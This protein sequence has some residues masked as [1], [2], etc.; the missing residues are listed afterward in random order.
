MRALRQD[1]RSF[2][3]ASTPMLAAWPV[4]IVEYFHA[5]LNQYFMTANTEQIDLL[6]SLGR[7]KT[8]W[9]RTGETMKGV[10]AWGDI[11][12]I[13]AGGTPTE[14]RNVIRFYGSPLGPNTHFYTAEVYG[15]CGHY[16]ADGKTWLTDTCEEEILRRVEIANAGNAHTLHYEGVDFRTYVTVRGSPGNWINPPV[17]CRLTDYYFPN[18]KPMRTVYRLYNGQDGTRTRADGSRIDGNHRYTTSMTIA[19]RMVAQGWTFE[20]PVWCERGFELR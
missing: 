4:T 18:E 20:G 10:S 7:D 12:K 5:G 8:G 11:W 6:D 13:S 14:P 9:A 16:A 15:Y 3:I 19:D 1:A 2:A 17:D